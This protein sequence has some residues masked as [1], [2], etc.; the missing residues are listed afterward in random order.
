VLLEVRSVKSLA[1]PGWLSSSTPRSRRAGGTSGVELLS[2][3]LSPPVAESGWAVQAGEPR[4]A[5]D[6]LLVSFVAQ[7]RESLAEQDLG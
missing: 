3:Q 6:P 4:S 5:N 7:V 1:Q 2:D